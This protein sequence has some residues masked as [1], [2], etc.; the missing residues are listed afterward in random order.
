MSHAGAHVHVV[1]HEKIDPR[2][3]TERGKPGRAQLMDEVRRIIESA[4]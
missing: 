3:Y 4:L 2:P 1:V